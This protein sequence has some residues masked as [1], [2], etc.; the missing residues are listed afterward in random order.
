[1]KVIEKIIEKEVILHTSLKDKRICFLDIETTGLSKS[2]DTIYLIGIMYFDNEISNWKIVQLFAEE[3][4]EEV[5]IL[6]EAYK[7]ISEFDIIV[8]YNG[9]SFDIP[10]INNKFNYYKM[11]MSIDVNISLDIYRVIKSNRNI[12]PLEN[13]KL[14]SI[15]EFLGIN[16]EDKHTGKEC[17]NFYF[18]YLIS[19]NNLAV[20][21]ILLH[22]YDD[23]YY[24]L[25][26]VNILNVIDSK[27]T[28]NVYY[29][30]KDNHFYIENIQL[31][32]DYL[33]ISGSV[34]DDNN[35]GNIV[36]YDDKYKL[37]IT[38]NNTFEISLEVMEGM[39]TPTKK[40]IFINSKDFSFSKEIEWRNVY[41]IPKGLII[42]EV[43][44]LFYIENIKQVISGLINNILN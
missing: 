12:L 24:L 26:V 18:D 27:N 42:L 32:K 5:D 30:N 36:Y 40:C 34:D 10:F 22:N 21:N 13:L 17:I 20:E 41:N 4:K 14:K 39:V 35:I 33:Y 38:K 9:T 3:L 2:I 7:I 15:E 6:L 25:D 1:M 44:K 23:L 28:M 43:E 11:N 31:N 16:R 37:I 19:K 29:N 8:N